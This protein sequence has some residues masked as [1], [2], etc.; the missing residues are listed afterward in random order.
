MNCSSFGHKGLWG[1]PVEGEQHRKRALTTVELLVALLFVL[2]VIGGAVVAFVALQRHA[3]ETKAK[4]NAMAEARHALMSL[5]NDLAQAQLGPAYLVP[6]DYFFGSNEVQPGGNRKDDDND[7][8]IDE[9]VFDGQDDDGDWQAGDDRHR[10]ISPGLFE[11]PQGRNRADFGDAKVDEDTKFSRAA[12]LF[13]I[14]SETTG[15][16]TEV[17]YRVGTFDE[18]PNVLIREKVTSSATEAGPI[19]FN[20]LSFSALFWDG[21]EPPG[22]TRGWVTSWDSTTLTGAGDVPLPVSVLLEVTVYAGRRPYSE[23]GPNDPIETVRLTTVVNVEAALNHPD[24]ER[25]SLP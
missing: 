24:Y 21:N 2:A 4:L 7:G 15:S 3:E 17:R 14:P 10:E 8:A 20:V 12:L 9:E 6:K 23:L 18:I 25:N 16:V 5:A 1:R 22:P 13:R 19:A 11:R